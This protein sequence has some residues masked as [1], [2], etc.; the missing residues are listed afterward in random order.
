MNFYHILGEQQLLT[1]VSKKT[2]TGAGGLVVLIEANTVVVKQ[3]VP[4]TVK[5]RRLRTVTHHIVQPYY[6]RHKRQA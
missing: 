4:V 5:Q 1:D 3:R 2:K 6:T